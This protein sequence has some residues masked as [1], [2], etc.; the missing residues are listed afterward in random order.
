MNLLHMRYAVEVARQGSLS[1][2]AEILRTAQPNI[3]RALKELE[4]DI[5]VTLFNRSKRGM[6][7]TD[8]GADFIAYARDILTRLDEMES[9]YKKGLHPKRRFRLLAPDAPYIAEAMAGLAE[10]MGGEPY[11]IS[12]CAA[13]MRDML[14]AVEEGDSRLC[15]IRYSADHDD[16]VKTA[17]TEKGLTYELVAEFSLGVLIADGHPLADASS[18]SLQSLAAY[19]ELVNADALDSV[20]RGRNVD[21]TV[22]GDEAAESARRIKVCG[23]AACMEALVAQPN[24]YMWSAPL[25]DEL[26]MR[27]GLIWRHPDDEGRVY[28]DVLIYREGHRLTREELQFITFLVSARRRHMPH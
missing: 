15:I 17:L 5:G 16:M 10:E 8:E 20:A 22:S 28:K 12:Y 21:A 11:E 14:R 25:S 27:H 4:T 9:L 7:L 19:V 18:I 26:L 6:V 3:S 23:R 1:R 13:P 2:A 24:A